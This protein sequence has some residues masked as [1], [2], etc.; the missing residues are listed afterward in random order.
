MFL[1]A[2]VDDLLFGGTWTTKFKDK[3]KTFFDMEDLG[4]AK[5]ALGIR[6]I[7]GKGTIKLIQDKYI[8]SILTKFQV[9]NNRDT[10]ITLPSN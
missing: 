1:Y 6:I 3:I 9:H 8:N 4:L 2:H 10:A 5:Y 7:Q